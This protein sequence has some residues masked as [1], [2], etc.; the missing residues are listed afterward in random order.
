MIRFCKSVAQNWLFEGGIFLRD[1]KYLAQFTALF[2]RFK[3]CQDFKNGWYA[4]RQL[5]LAT[6]SMSIIFMKNA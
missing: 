1:E 3:L 5:E 6:K 2:N 4:L